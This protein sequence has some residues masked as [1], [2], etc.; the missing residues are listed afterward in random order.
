MELPPPRDDVL[1]VEALPRETAVPPLLLP[2]EP[3]ERCSL[4][5]EP[6]DVEV[7]LGRGGSGRFGTDGG[8]TRLSPPD[9][10]EDVSPDE[11]DPDDPED[12]ELP[13]EPE[14]VVG[15]GSVRLTARWAHAHEGTARVAATAMP[16][17]NRVDLAITDSSKQALVQLYCHGGGAAIPNIPRRLPGR[18][19]L[20]LPS[21]A[22]GT[23]MGNSS[24]A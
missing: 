13:D 24:P 18:C 8:E 3:D 22:D 21:L 16:I 20:S 10:R 5:D 17:A 1:P 12:P 19:P 14:L 11:L 15:G 23:T 4:L 7:R 6:D 2:L 9:V